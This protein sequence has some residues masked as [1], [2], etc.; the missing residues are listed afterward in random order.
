V[1]SSNTKII[2]RWV[3]PLIFS[4]LSFV[5]TYLYLESISTNGTFSYSIKPEFGIS[6]ST[7]VLC[8]LVFCIGWTLGLFI[9]QLINRWKDRIGNFMQIVLLAPLCFIFFAIKIPYSLEISIIL[10]IYLLY[11]I[12]RTTKNYKLSTKNQP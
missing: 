4:I 6:I 12:Y 9:Y 11:C 8:I 10:S 3:R 1:S 7:L 2:W 5:S